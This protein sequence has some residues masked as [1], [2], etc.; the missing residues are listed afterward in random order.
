MIDAG[1]RG[2]SKLGPLSLRERLM[3]DRRAALGDRSCQ[4]MPIS[5][6][7]LPPFPVPGNNMANS[8]LPWDIILSVAEGRHNAAL[9]IP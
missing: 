2:G 1:E 5:A 9:V 4:R 3:E 8:C 7:T 6:D